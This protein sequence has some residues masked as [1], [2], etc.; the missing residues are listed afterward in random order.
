MTNGASPCL[1]ETTCP[2]RFAL[3]EALPPELIAAASAAD[4]HMWDLGHY[5]LVGAE[6]YQLCPACAEAFS[7]GRWVRLLRLA[8]ARLVK[9]NEECS[10]EEWWDAL[11]T[12]PELVAVVEPGAST[13]A[14][15]FFATLD[16][17]R[18]LI[19][20]PGWHTPDGHPLLFED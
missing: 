19:A 17:I 3:V 10:G 12:R 8:D 18:E 20:L 11:R 14:M 6:R 2:E 1:V 9:V 7:A 5:S 4:L 16:Q 15:S 13:T